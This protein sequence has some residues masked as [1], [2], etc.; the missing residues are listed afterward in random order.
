M[1]VTPL[2]LWL[3]SAFTKSTGRRVASA[4]VA[5]VLRRSWGSGFSA[6]Q[7]DVSVLEFVSCNVSALDEGFKS[8]R[9]LQQEIQ[10]VDVLP[11]EHRAQVHSIRKLRLTVIEQW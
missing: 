10:K 1:S 5:P 8:A 11:H 6:N 7:R 9:G 3:S 2:S 4:S